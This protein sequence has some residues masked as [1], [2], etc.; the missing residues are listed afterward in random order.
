MCWVS[1][2]RRAIYYQ[3]LTFAVALVFNNNKAWSVDRIVE[4]AFHLMSS[5]LLE[6]IS[7]IAKI[8]LTLKLKGVKE[9]TRRRRGRDGVGVETKREDAGE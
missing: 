7:K 5:K 1:G 4:L 2:E 8:N 3:A 9:M 6:T